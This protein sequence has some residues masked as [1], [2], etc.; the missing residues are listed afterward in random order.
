MIYELCSTDF[1]LF[2]IAAFYTHY[3]TYMAQW[4][5]TKGFHWVRKGLKEGSPNNQQN[6]IKNI[7]AHTF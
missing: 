3:S 5:I 7:S 6:E 4:L 2:Y 1:L